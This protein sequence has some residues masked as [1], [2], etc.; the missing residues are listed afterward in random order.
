MSAPAV[1]PGTK[2]AER[3]R[4]EDRVAEQDGAILW[5]A[6]DEVLARPVAVHTF[7]DSYARTSEVVMAARA[8]SRLSDPRLT[9]V[10][11]AAEEEQ[12]SYVVS[13]W[14]TGET[15]A[16]LLAAGPLEPERAAALVAEAAEALAHA[17]EAGLAH[18]CLRPS[19]LIWTSGSTVKVLGVGIDAA[20][21][22]L[23]SDDPAGD[24][25]AG[26]GRL[27]YAGLTGHWPGPSDGPVGLPPAPT[28]PDGQICTPRQVTA[29]IPGYLDGITVRAALP[30]ALRGQEP[31][32]S[33]AD[34]AEALGSVPR[35]S[36]VPIATLPPSVHLGP[37]GGNDDIRFEMSQPM[38][39][40]MSRP[41]DPVRQH[42]HGPPTMPPSMPG[43]HQRRPQRPAMVNR[44]IMTVVVL[45]VMAVVG[46]G[47][48]TLGR[49]IAGPTAS[50]A[51]PT[52]S[53]TPTAKPTPVKASSAKDF[54]PKG[55]DGGENPEYTRNAI[56]D[57][58]GTEWH[59]DT[60]NTAEFGRLKDGV[61]LMLDMGKSVKVS[62]VTVTF[63]KA[64]GA[65]AEIRVGDSPDLDALKTVAK[66]S[67][68]SG[69]TT[70][71]P[72]EAASGQYVL[73]WFT[74]LPADQGRFRGTIYDVVVYSPGSA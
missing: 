35:P 65:K 32:V 22:D 30:A 4:V 29:G 48:W 41:M 58:S 43:P 72:T 45:V 28:T 67:N 62:E 46:I 23:S 37:R 26:L 52:V 5:K 2:L 14:V 40:T 11:D 57:K 18:L 36:P 74:R 6:I 21:G 3:F 56:D 24:D 34:V 15:L 1:E 10:F 19:K 70:F 59:T 7:S 33:P 13:E 71:K 54:D 20:L 44:A 63:A 60:Y 68:A 25:A 53:A 9:Q 39:R 73:I 16:D 69:K 38:P 55:T 42:P 49:S 47:A 64:S 66:Q 27:L 50:K 31:L 51:E 12:L 17:H 8:A 61:G